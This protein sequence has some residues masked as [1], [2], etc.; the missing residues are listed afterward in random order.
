MKVEAYKCSICGS[1]HADE[2]SF[3]S[4]EK[5]CAA[6]QLESARE[7]E[8][9]NNMRTLRDYPRLNATSFPHLIQLC[10]EKAKEMWGVEL[11]FRLDVAY[12]PVVSNSHSAPVGKPTNWGGNV[13]L[14]RGYEGFSG[15]ITGTGKYLKPVKNPLSSSDFFGGTFAQGFT[16]INTGSGG[17]GA[18]FSYDVRL[19]LEDFP[20]IAESFHADMEAIERLQKEVEAEQQK[21]EE[22]IQ[23]DKLR[24]DIQ[25]EEFKVEQQIEELRRK[26]MTLQNKRSAHEAQ[27][28]AT[29]HSKISDCQQ[30]IRTYRNTWKVGGV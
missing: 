26:H 23:S 17:G 20:V 3:N 21:A 25:I 4:C 12:S 2:D 19:Y 5:D 8:H 1:L 13:K 11:N 10:K 16:G 22:I 27:I 14:P 28:A 24:N 6:K 7:V 29:P 18:E 15:R 9:S 30:R